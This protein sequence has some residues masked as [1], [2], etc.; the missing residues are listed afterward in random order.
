[1]CY[2]CAPA[3]SAPIEDETIDLI[4]VAQALHWFNV[5]AF[6][7]E[8][9]RVLRPDG[10]LAVWCYGWTSVSPEIDPLVKT[11]ATETVG[12]YWP[13]DRRHIGRATKLCR[14]LSKEGL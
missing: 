8:A 13:E 11:F 7:Q 9:H 5:E 14:F 1:M 6:Y 12:P 4:T 10:V 2:R 3:E